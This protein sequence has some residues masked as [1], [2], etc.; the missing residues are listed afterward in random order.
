MFC[1]G[2]NI[3]WFIIGPYWGATLLFGY[4]MH[5]T[6]NYIFMYEFLFMLSWALFGLHTTLWNVFVVLCYEYGKNF[7]ILI[8][9]KNKIKEKIIE[10]E[11]IKKFKVYYDR[12]EDIMG[13]CIIILNNM[14]EYLISSLQHFPYIGGHFRLLFEH[15]IEENKMD[16]MDEMDNMS[17][18]VERK[19]D[20][21]NGL[22]NNNE[23]REKVK[24]E[25][26]DLQKIIG[27]MEGMDEDAEV[28][29]NLADVQKFIG[30]LE[31]I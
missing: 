1:F 30:L 17:M 10:H 11:K 14:I 4:L 22:E 9:K 20:E 21:I 13:K 26:D 6:R 25:I 23:I 27:M 8:D 16:K 3:L 28:K 12:A 19:I 5:D 15:K 2:L 18:Q 29:Q 7:E 31:N 24:K